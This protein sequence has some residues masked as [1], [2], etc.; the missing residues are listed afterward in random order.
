MN[1]INEIEVALTIVRSTLGSKLSNKEYSEIINRDFK[2]DSTE[3]DINYLFE[4]TIEN[5]IEDLKLIY[6]NL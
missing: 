1:K 4:P 6:N 3:E 5:D 2:L